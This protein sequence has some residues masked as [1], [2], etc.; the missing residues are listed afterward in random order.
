MDTGI[1]MAPVSDAPVARH[2]HRSSPLNFD[3]LT[4]RWRA[5]RKAL[6]YRQAIA[7]MNDHMLRDIGLHDH[8]PLWLR[9][10]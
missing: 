6:R 9:R 8:N 3:T 7:M 4:E 1:E 2:S 10:R 5:R